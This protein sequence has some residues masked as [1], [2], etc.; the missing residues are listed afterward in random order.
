[1]HG[2]DWSA[3]SNL[4]L[5]EFH[6]DKR[7][8]L[9]GVVSKTSQSRDIYCMLELSLCVT[10]YERQLEVEPHPALTRYLRLMALLVFICY[11]EILHYALDTGLIVL[12]LEVPGINQLTVKIYLL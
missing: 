3:F 9:M 2:Q 6:I 5:T 11:Q 1:M 7:T 8:L 4:S 10:N 12:C